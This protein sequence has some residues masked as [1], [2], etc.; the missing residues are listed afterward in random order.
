MIIGS[1]NNDFNVLMIILAIERLFGFHFLMK[2]HFGQVSLVNLMFQQ[3]EL[4]IKFLSRKTFTRGL[5]VS[6]ISNIQAWFN[7]SPK[8]FLIS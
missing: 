5:L 6:C 1:V 3:V 4:D 7:N 8:Y 2:L